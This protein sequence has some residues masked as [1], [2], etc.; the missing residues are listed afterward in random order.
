MKVSPYKCDYC[1]QLQKPGDPPWFLRPKDAIGFY[2]LWWDTELAD[3][4]RY[5]HVCSQACA[6]KAMSKWAAEGSA[7]EPKDR[8]ARREDAVREH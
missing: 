6:M 4:P 1:G 3:E 8:T 7:N 2:M 5:E